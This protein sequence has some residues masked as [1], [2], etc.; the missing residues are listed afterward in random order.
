[1][2]AKGTTHNNGLKLA[3]YITT[4]KDGERAELWKLDGFASP[5]I[6]QAFRCVHVMAEATKCEQ[7]FFHVQVRNREGEKLTR[8]QWE[9]TAHRIIR[10]N[11]L[12]GQPYAIAFHINEITGEEHMHLAVSRID[13]ETMKARPLPFFQERLSKISRELE[14]E[15]GLEPVRSEREGPIKYAPKRWEAE[16]AHRLGFDKDAIRNTIRACHDR[17]DCGRDFDNELANEGLILALGNRR[18]YVV[19]DHAGGIHALGQRILGM[20]PRDL[21]VKL[22]DL[23]HANIPTIEQAKELMLDLPRDR[24]DRLTRELADVQ[25]QIKAEHEYARRDPVRDEIQWQDALDKAAIAKEKTERQFVEPKERE[26]E[27]T[28]AEREQ[29]QAGGREE[30]VWPINPPQHQ[31]WPGFEKAASEATRDDRTENLKGPAAQVWTAWQQSDSAQAFAAALDDK[32]IAFAAVTGEEAYRS[33]READFARAAGNHS[34]RFKEGEI[35]MVTEPPLEY[36]RDDQTFIPSRIHKLDQSL[37]YKFRRGLTNGNPLPGIDATLKVSDERAQQRA[38]YRE[39][40]RLDRATDIR[41]F[42][43]S[44]P[45]NAKDAIRVSAK[46]TTNALGGIGAGL[47]KGAEFVGEAISSLFAPKLSPEQIRKGEITQQRREADAE[48]SIDYSRYTAE[49]TQQRRQEE[50]DREA[51][52]QRQRD[53]ERGRER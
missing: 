4:G 10:I 37:A 16:Q 29:K 41:D 17:T 25:A 38:A 3:Q 7:P 48:A 35:V 13:A 36:R 20:K 39:A 8:Q 22:A 49:R 1:M 47:G 23:D 30:K 15:F 14:K 42:S 51:E 12:T 33:H 9:V 19:I 28:R 24:A 26:K 52:R 18:D 5:D 2:I 53:E 44:I 21:R 46:I 6:K 45:G 50:T 27:T 32:G 34:L 40:V 43:K 31:S 11:G